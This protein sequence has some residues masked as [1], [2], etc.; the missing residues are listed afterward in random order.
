MRKIKK[1]LAAIAMGLAFM[2]TL[3]TSLTASAYTYY[4]DW[5]PRYFTP[6]SG[7]FY[8]SEYGVRVTDMYWSYASIRRIQ[9]EQMQVEYIPAKYTAEFE[10]RPKTSGGE[11]LRPNQ[12]WSSY[13]SF[14]SNMPFAY[15][16]YEL[17]YIFA[18]DVTIGCGCIAQ[19][20]AGKAYYGYLNLNKAA[21]PP[22]GSYYEFNSEY[23]L[24]P[25]TASDP[26]PYYDEFYNLSKTFFNTTYS[27]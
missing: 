6:Q 19:S 2:A 17:G 24:L 11:T 15:S 4:G 8:A 13:K 3:A 22:S 20:T 25:G 10:F 14:S 27:W 7:S 21:S 12:I 16:E 26:T 1:K 23:G 18:N 5:G 9:Q